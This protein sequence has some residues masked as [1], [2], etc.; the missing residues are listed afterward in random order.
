MKFIV[1]LL[2]RTKITIMI[3]KK[4]TTKKTIFLIINPDTNLFVVNKF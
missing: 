4:E 3:N 1:K 2:M